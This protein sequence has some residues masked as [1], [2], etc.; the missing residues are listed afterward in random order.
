MEGK[1][2]PDTDAYAVFDPK[3]GRAR[4]PGAGGKSGS[5][6]PLF[7]A[8]RGPQTTLQDSGA[9]CLSPAAMRAGSTPLCR[10]W[11]LR[12]RQRGGRSGRRAPSRRPSCSC[13]AGATTSSMSR[14]GG[15][16]PV[17]ARRQPCACRGVRAGFAGS[18]SRSSARST[19]DSCRLRKPSRAC[20]RVE[21]CCCVALRAHP[22]HPALPRALPAP[23]AAG[24][25]VRSPPPSTSCT[26]PPT[27]SRG[28]SSC[29]SCP[30]WGTRAAQRP[31]HRQRRHLRTDGCCCAA[32]CEG[33]RSASTCSAPSRRCFLRNIFVSPLVPPCS[34][35]NFDALLT[36]VYHFIQIPARPPG[37]VQPTAVAHSLAGFNR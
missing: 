36:P 20:A 11:M 21:G 37:H 33:K 25:A 23:A 1:P 35:L 22:P 17:L 8:P 13:W 18:H 4:L 2:S 24:P 32:C 34:A 29:S 30:C 3:V 26:V 14:S 16:P 28:S 6:P 19:R 10:P 27:C 31:L 9:P 12:R 15:W 5:C 7:A